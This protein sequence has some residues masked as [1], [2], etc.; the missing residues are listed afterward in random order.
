M[1]N[2]HTKLKRSIDEPQ[3]CHRKPSFIIGY[4]RDP[5]NIADLMLPGLVLPTEGIASFECFERDELCIVTLKGNQFVQQWVFQGICR[6]VY[7]EFIIEVDDQF[8]AYRGV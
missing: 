2:L 3:F 8:L 5:M 4:H 6:D 1:G 7:E